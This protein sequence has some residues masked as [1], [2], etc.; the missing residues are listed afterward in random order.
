MSTEFLVCLAGSLRGID[1]KRRQDHAG[2]RNEVQSLPFLPVQIECS[3]DFEQLLFS[4]IGIVTAFHWQD[5]SLQ[6]FPE[7]G[8]QLPPSPP[9]VCQKS[10]LW[11]DKLKAQKAKQKI[12]E[13]FAKG[14]EK[15]IRGYTVNIALISRS[16]L[17]PFLEFAYENIQ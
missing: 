16:D 3:L 1:Q 14:R 13:G 6:K 15:E 17:P 7:L 2:N 4:L 10:L 8:T 5:N 9:T 12:P 11:M